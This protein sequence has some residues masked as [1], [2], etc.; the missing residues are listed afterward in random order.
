[1][2]KLIIF[3]YFNYSPFG[4]KA[5]LTI[6]KYLDRSPEHFCPV[7]KPPRLEPSLSR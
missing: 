3:F 6:P 4:P 1:M 5:E 2:T 7:H